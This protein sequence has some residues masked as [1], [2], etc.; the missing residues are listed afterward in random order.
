ML[1][2]TT[3]IVHPTGSVCRLPKL[4][5][6]FSS[7]GFARSKSQETG[8][9]ISHSSHALMAVGGTITGAFLLSAFDMFH[10]LIESPEI[11]YAGKELIFVDSG[12]YELTSS[13]DSTEPNEVD[14][15]RDERFSEDD[16]DSVLSRL[17]EDLPFVV[18]NYDHAA[19]GLKMDTQI[20]AASTLLDEYPS[21]LHNFIAKPTS[22][23]SRYI[24]I[25]DIISHLDEL[26]HFA[27]LGVTEREIGNTVRKRLVNIATLRLAMD[28]RGIS[29]PIHVWGGL[30]P[31]MTPMYFCAGAEIFDGVSW[32]R[33]GYYNNASIPRDAYTVLELGVQAGPGPSVY[34][35][36]MHNLNYLE[37]A[38]T[39]MERFVAEGCADFSLFGTH[40]EAIESGY[41]AMTSRIA[42]SGR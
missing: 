24:N 34:L 6:S 5:P 4:V 20:R 1:A 35:R 10:G 9:W 33:Y 7:K 27:V 38:E 40:S 17:P 28:D 30:D 42:R 12:G 21:F 16:Y 36:Y 2:R 29:M 3:E 14:E 39:Q 37:K 41:R 22:K 32:M 26:R 19:R 11:Y 8:A 13:M 31:V 25:D 23:R 18:A 15:Q